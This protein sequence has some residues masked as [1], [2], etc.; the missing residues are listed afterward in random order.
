[1]RAC[2]CPGASVS[3]QRPTTPMLARTRWPYMTYRYSVPFSASADLDELTGS[4]PILEY[5]KT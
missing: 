3:M 1:V 2:H 4:D 5:W